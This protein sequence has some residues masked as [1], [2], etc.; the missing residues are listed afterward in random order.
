MKNHQIPVDLT[1]VGDTIEKK[2]GAIPTV[3]L[4]LFYELTIVCLIYLNRI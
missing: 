4:F 1:K 2:N 3:F